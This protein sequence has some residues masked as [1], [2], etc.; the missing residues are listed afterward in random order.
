V[1]AIIPDL[2]RSKVAAYYVSEVREAASVSAV[3]ELSRSRE[4]V[5]T[6]FHAASIADA[7]V[8]F[9]S[10]ADRILGHDRA[11]IMTGQ[12][13]EGVFYVNVVYGTSKYVPVIEFLPFQKCPPILKALESGTT[14]QIADAVN[15][16]IEKN[17]AQGG[18][19]IGRKL[20]IDNAKRLGLAELAASAALPPATQV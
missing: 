5:I 8:S 13:L 16:E 11:R 6:T 4:P 15:A 10:L 14:R 18:T 2:L 7:V 3:L 19:A 12:M 1:D 9:M 17:T 20:A